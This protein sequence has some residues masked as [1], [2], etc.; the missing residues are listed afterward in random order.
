L[1][2][3]AG[4]PETAGKKL[5]S[6]S[7]WDD[8]DGKSGNGTD[9][10]GFSAL[11]GG[12]KYYNRHFYILCCEY[13][14]SFVGEVGYWWTATGENYGVRMVYQSDYANVNQYRAGRPS[15]YKSVRCVADNP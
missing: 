7:G 3:T 4:G 5:K 13:W 6:T 9:D 2:T 14:Y 8:Y 10:F 15:G 1:I 11:P 12:S